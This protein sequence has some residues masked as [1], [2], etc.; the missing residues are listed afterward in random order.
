MI[1]YRKGAA[2]SRIINREAAAF[3]LL[4]Q[5]CRGISANQ[6]IRCNKMDA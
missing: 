3:L 4:Q 6:A 5:I 1:G 2:V